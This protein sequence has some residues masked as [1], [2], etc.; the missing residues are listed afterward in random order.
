MFEDRVQLRNRLFTKLFNP[1][2]AG[3]KTKTSHLLEF[4]GER[5]VFVFLVSSDG[6]FTSSAETQHVAELKPQSWPPAPRRLRVE[7]LCSVFTC[8]PASFRSAHQR[9]VRPP[10]SDPA[11]G[12]FHLF[13]SPRGWKLGSRLKLDELFASVFQAPPAQNMFLRSK[14]ANT[15]LVEEILQGN[16]E[17]ECY[18]ERCSY[19]E[20]RE[21]FEDTKRTVGP[22]HTDGSV[23]SGRVPLTLLCTLSADLLL[24]R[25]HR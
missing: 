14:R 8:W 12:C 21:V 25:L 6:C 7:R 18:E 19:E 10:T 4:P 15:F 23:G 22:A 24:D 13:C 11:D 9:R 16:L 1:P 3:E 2:A 20:A 5:H 17:R